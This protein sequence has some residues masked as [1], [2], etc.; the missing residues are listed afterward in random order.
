MTTIDAYTHVLTE[1]F[2]DTLVAEYDFQGLSGDPSFLWDLDRRLDDMD[3][4]GVDK[5]VLTL[6]LP[7]LWRGMD[8]ETALELTQLANDE[9]RSIADEHPDRFVPVGTIPRVSD[10][11][12]A[13]FD[14]CVEDLDMAGV[15]MFSNIEGEPI[16]R[17]RFRPLFERAERHD[18]PLWMHPQLHEWYDWAS[19]YM[20]HRLFGW[21]FDTTLALS[22][23]VFGGV[24]DEY[25]FDLVA[26]HGGGM[27]PFYGGRIDSFY[28]TRLDYPENY[29]DTDLPD[30]DQPV[31]DYFREFHV[32]TA[33]SGS[34]LAQECATGFFGDEKV[35]FGT[36]YP[37]GP[38]RGRA[39]IEQ[40][41][42]AVEEMDASEETRER[43]LGGNLEDLFG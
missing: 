35:V 12:M 15:Q 41:L 11:F 1:E 33:V 17:P 7:P 3:E 21:P 43:I 16:D 26:H 6:A 32:D 39:W 9:V 4:F 34:V 22:R 42:D 5:Q 36:D 19:E 24:V 28:Q 37:F 29:A 18:A 30:L 14:R 23:L 31:S 27:V 2:Y 20:E 8:D 10:E 38:G 40:G 13:E 25:D